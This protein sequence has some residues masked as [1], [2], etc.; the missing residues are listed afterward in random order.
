VDEFHLAQDRKLSGCCE[1]G[2]EPSGYIKG[3]QLLDYMSHHQLLKKECLPCI[4]SF[5]NDAVN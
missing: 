5:L 4:Y 3:R 2:N 1:H